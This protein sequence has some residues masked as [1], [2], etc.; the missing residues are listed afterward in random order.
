VT[1]IHELRNRLTTAI[2]TVTAMIDGKMPSTR[3]NL[4]HVG[5]TLA[6]I[7]TIVAKGRDEDWGGDD[8]FVDLAEIAARVIDA[9][10]MLS[11][12]ANVNLILASPFNG[13]RAFRA[14]PRPIYRALDGAVQ[15]LLRAAP[16]GSTLEIEQ[17]SA[18]SVNLVL[19]SPKDEAPGSDPF[20]P[21]RR[22][23][24][25]Y[26]GHA[27]RLSDMKTGYCLQFPGVPACGC[28]VGPA[29]E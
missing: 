10:M 3:G 5:Q 20:E 7:E 16:A 8:R 28:A 13:C 25:T 19:H 1:E 14:D 15:T 24:E 29:C 2:L 17:A 4:Q 21:I 11:A 6:D 9:M 23:L 27:V 26:G 18:Q 22:C 12:A